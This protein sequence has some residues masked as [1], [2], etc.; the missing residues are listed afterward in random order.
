MISGDALCAASAID[1]VIALLRTN[2]KVIAMDE[3]IARDPRTGLP[4]S[5]VKTRE[6]RKRISD[7][8]APPDGVWDA[9]RLFEILPLCRGEIANT[10][11]NW[12]EKRHMVTRVDAVRALPRI[13]RREVSGVH[14]ELLCALQDEQ[15]E[16][17]ISG[18]FALPYCA[19]VCDAEDFFARLDELLDDDS[20]V[21]RSNASE[22]LVK[23]APIFPSG[24]EHILSRELRNEMPVRKKAGFKALKKLAKE[25]PEVAALHLDELLRLDDNMTRI[26]ASKLLLSLSKAPSAAIWDLI[27]WSLADEVDSVR[28]NAAKTL[29]TLANHSPHIAKALIENSLFDP[30]SAVRKHALRALPSVDL[31]GPRMMKLCLDG[32]RHEDPD[33][34]GACIKMIPR[35][36]TESRMREEADLLLRQET[37]PNLIKILEEMV[38]DPELEGGEDEKN[39]FLAPSEA[40]TTEDGIPLPLPDLVVRD[41]MVIDVTRVERG[42]LPEQTESFPEDSEE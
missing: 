37:R 18:L 20:A 24:I 19:I 4:I 31:G 23:V 12:L 17:K 33:M 29:P 38:Y 2:G 11:V 8:Y 41:G 9:I 21:V 34:R 7:S 30:S 10:E 6:K 40:P 5:N 3:Y 13:V 16:V 35:L 42:E 27:Q 1:W 36:F 15:D 14:T 28:A 39:R 25:W 26:E 32:A 22:C